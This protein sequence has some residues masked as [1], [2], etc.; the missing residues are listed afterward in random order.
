MGCQFEQFLPAPEYLRT[1][2]AG[3]TK[4]RGILKPYVTKCSLVYL[5]WGD[6]ASSTTAS[7][8]VDATHRH[9]SI[10]R[11]TSGW[12]G[13]PQRPHVKYSNSN[14]SFFF[15]EMKCFVGTKFN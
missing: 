4:R 2:C 15:F 12:W 10:Q 6:R 11:V 5:R 9:C 8:I 7:S 1:M 3:Q 13:V 14:T